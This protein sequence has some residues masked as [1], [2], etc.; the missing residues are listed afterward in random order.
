MKKR[1]A[2]ITGAANGIGKAIATRLASEG[3]ITVLI[4]ID[5]ANGNALADEFGSNARYIHCNISDETEVASM[6]KTVVDQFGSVDILVNNAGYFITGLAE[7]TPI[8]VGLKQFETNF[9][10]TVKLTNAILPKMRNQ[11]QGKPL[12]ILYR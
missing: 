8:H 9:W 7:E 3:Y 1:V 6:F 12:V 5:D 2:I 10:G 4:D 11:R